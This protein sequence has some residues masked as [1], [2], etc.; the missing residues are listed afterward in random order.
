[1]STCDKNTTIGAGVGTVAGTVLTGGSGI[2]TVGSGGAVGGIIGHE[3]GRKQHLFSNRN[4]VISSRRFL[5]R[6]TITYR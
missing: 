3:V 4:G 5:I 1:M 6:L 2:V